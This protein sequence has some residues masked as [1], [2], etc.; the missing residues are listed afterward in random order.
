M[1]NKLTAGIGNAFG[2]RAPFGPSTT[3]L[4]AG[5][6]HPRP[7]L[8]RGVVCR[9]IRQN[10]T[11]LGDFRGSVLGRLQRIAFNRPIMDDRIRC[12]R[13]ERSSFPAE[14]C[15]RGRGD[16]E[17]GGTVDDRL[18]DGR[19]LTEKGLKVQYDSDR[20]EVL[21][22]YPAFS[23]DAIIAL[24]ARTSIRVIGHCSNCVRVRNQT[25]EIFTVHFVEGYRMR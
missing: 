12:P 10:S 2:E 25:P 17:F 4:L 9:R 20:C 19:A 6:K 22:S 3:G 13:F 15:L 16:G 24:S 14:K 21:S 18:S 11:R 5:R 23:F 1:A 7:L 8:H